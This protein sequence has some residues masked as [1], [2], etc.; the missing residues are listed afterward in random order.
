MVHRMRKPDETLVD[1]CNDCIEWAKSQKR[2]FLRQRVETRLCSV[3]S[4]LGKYEPAL[5]MLGELVKDV[6]IRS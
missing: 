4:D 6:R 2:T 1:L 5:K 3:Y